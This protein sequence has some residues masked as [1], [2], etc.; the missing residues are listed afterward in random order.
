MAKGAGPMRERVAFDQKVAVADDLGGDA[1]SWSEIFACAAEFRY[2]RG[3]ERVEA[4]GLTG[5]ATFKVRVRACVATRGLSQED[6][7]RDV[8]RSVAYNIR[9]IDAVSDP[10]HVWLV[11]E[12]GVAI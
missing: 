8:R 12:S 9:E 5:Q 2:Q 3:G 1:V 11:A 6:R 7:M 10:A 4:G